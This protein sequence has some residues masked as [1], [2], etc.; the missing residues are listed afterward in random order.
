[1]SVLRVLRVTYAKFDQARELKGGYSG[2]G[3]PG[4]VLV[5]ACKREEQIK[6]PTGKRKKGVVEMVGTMDIKHPNPNCM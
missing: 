6:R 4:E 1:M 2:E 5:Y 3:P